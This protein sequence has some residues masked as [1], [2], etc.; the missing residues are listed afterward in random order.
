MNFRKTFSVLLAIGLLGYLIWQVIDLVKSR[1]KPTQWSS[2]QKSMMI[3]D[4]I[5]SSKVL[6]S[7]DIITANS[8]C[9]CAMEKLTGKYTYDQIWELDEQARENKEKVLNLFEH[10][11]QECMTPYLKEIKIKMEV[12]D[13]VNEATRN[14]KMT[15]EHANAYCTC[16]ITYLHEKYSEQQLDSIDLIMK[17]EITKAKECADNAMR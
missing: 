8:I 11:M 15:K 17:T 5:K 1:R 9:S 6:S 2:E 12:A 16:F 3:H 4:C 13:C 14:N 7:I 10:L